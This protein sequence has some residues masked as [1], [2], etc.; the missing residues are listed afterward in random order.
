MKVYSP[1]QFD[2]VIKRLN[3]EIKV[4]R[5]GFPEC[6]YHGYCCLLKWKKHK[7]TIPNGYILEKSCKNYTDWFDLHRWYGKKKSNSIPHRSFNNII[8]H[9]LDWGAIH[10]YQTRNI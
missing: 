8:K 2:N 4:Y 9:L 6:M 1:R 7:L 10:H 3:P 5:F